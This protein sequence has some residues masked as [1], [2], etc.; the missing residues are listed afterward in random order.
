MTGRAS[1]SEGGRSVPTAPLPRHSVRMDGAG[2]RCVDCSQYFPEWPTDSLGCAEAQWTH[3]IV[4]GPWLE[5]RGFRCRIVPDPG[6][7]TYPWDKPRRGEV[8]VFV[9]DDPHNQPS[10]F[11]SDEERGWTCV[12]GI[13]ALARLP[14]SADEAKK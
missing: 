5:R 4:G 1:S 12:I 7:G 10:Q 8:V 2:W 6:T 3:E 11:L 14:Y 9:E 13:D